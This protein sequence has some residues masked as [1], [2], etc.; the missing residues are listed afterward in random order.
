MN[1]ILTFIECNIGIN[2]YC[3]AAHK[4]YL[5]VDVYGVGF[6]GVSLLVPHGAIADDTSWEMYML[7][8]QGESR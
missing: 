2:V 1:L 7:I 6:L 3:V 5:S 4:W 8:N